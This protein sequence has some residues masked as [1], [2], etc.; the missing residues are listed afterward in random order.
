MIPLTPTLT[1]PESAPEPPK[2]RWVTRQHVAVKIA[3][4]VAITAIVFAIIDAASTTPETVTAPAATTPAAPIPTTLV[5]AAAPQVTTAPT[6]APTTVRTTGRTTT[7]RSQ[8]GYDYQI[9]DTI[10][11]SDV[12]VLIPD[13]WSE[14][15]M[16]IYT[17]SQVYTGYT[18]TEQ[19][20]MCDTFWAVSDSALVTEA[21]SGGISRDAAIG[22]VDLLWTVC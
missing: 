22:L 8:R 9:C 20:A 18:R 19:Q 11:V 1:P 4:I 21:M 7:P 2:Q 3:V 13:D 12:S 17:A 16:G 10:D 14:W 6:T 15:C 5:V